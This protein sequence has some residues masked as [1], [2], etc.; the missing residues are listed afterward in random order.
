[1]FIG[2]VSDPICIR[3]PVHPA[4]VAGKQSLPLAS[5]VVDV[6]GVLRGRRNTIHKSVVFNEE[7][8]LE[9]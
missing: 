2:I 5:L 1:M 7:S 6:P 9:V 8:C 4:F 3:I